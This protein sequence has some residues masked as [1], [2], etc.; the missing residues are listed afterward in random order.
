M[1]PER[2]R[3]LAYSEIQEKMSREESRVLKARKIHAVLDHFIGAGW[4][5]GATY[6]DI[7]SSLGWT[8]QAAAESGCVAMGIDIDVPGLV[9]ARADRDPRCFF[10]CADGEQLPF[11]DE[12]IDVVVFNHIY[13]HVVDPDAVMSEIRRVL[14]PSG[15]AYLGL[16]NRLGVMEPHHRLPFL[17]WLPEGIAD[18]Y[19]RTFHKA[20]RYHERF[21]TVPGLQRMVGG[22]YVHDYSY[23]I[24]AHPEVFSSSDMIGSWGATAV[25][26]AP[27]PVLRLAGT[28]IPTVIWV[29]SKSP[30]RPAGPS[31]VVAPSPVTTKL[32]PG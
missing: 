14:R 8:V 10:A 12:S 19:V 18:H 31:L 17:S 13:E 21:R 24:L 16:G 27:A 4:A 32:T 7:G 23:S 9:R 6:L 2:G 25:R 28:I 20:D 1:A 30:Q 3:Q 5:P 29:A 11:A 15:V 22:L 26:R